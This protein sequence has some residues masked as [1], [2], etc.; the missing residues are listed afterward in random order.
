MSKVHIVHTDNYNSE[1]VYAAVCRHFDALGVADVVKPGQK[2]VLKPNL[3]MKRTPEEFTTTHPTLVESVIRKLKELGVTD[4]TIADSPGGPYTKSLLTSVY[5]GCGLEEVAIRQGVTLNLDVGYVTMERQ[6]N[7]V[8]KSFSVIRPLAE[9]DVIINLC[10]L[11]THGMVGLS[12][13]VKNMFGA[14]PGLMKPELHLRFPEIE[15]FSEMLADLCQTV[16]STFTFVDAIDAMEGDGP[17]GGEKRHV[18]MTLAAI[19]PF[20]LDL[21]LCKVTNLSPETIYT[22]VA[23][24][25]RGASV[26]SVEEVELCG[27]ELLVFSDYKKAASS[28]LT[29]NKWLPKWLQKRLVPRPVILHRGCIGCAKCKES[30]P[31]DTIDIRDRKAYIDYKNCIR[32]YC[33][34]EMCPV[35]TIEIKRTRLYDWGAK[36]SKES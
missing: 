9:A 4:I 14:V 13:G 20:D 7:R 23:G 31:A 17:S 27:D 10:K 1:V 2:V 33:C 34:H 21:V 12:G 11:K 3:L 36:R 25:S 28:D 18:G 30:C 19:N 6:E 24:I 26:D 22:A 16:M 5:Q 15:L 32:C 8:C 35:R 29:F